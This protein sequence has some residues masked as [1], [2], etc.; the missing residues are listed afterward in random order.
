MRA[1]N[2]SAITENLYIGTTPRGAD[3]QHLKDLGVTMIINMRLEWPPLVMSRQRLF[4]V[5]WVPSIDSPYF[6]ISQ[7]RLLTAA[8]KAAKEI[9]QDGIVYA[10][11]QVGRHRSVIMAAAILILMGYDMQTI[12]KL[13]TTRRP[14]AD[15]TASQVRDA[16]SIFSRNYKHSLLKSKH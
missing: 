1:F 14:V 16:L 15:F 13:V 4:R 9:K 10:H 12:K 8:T 3:Y 5:V 11:C 6:P 7:K 2:Y